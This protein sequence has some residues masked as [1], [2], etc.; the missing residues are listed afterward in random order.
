MPDESPIQRHP[1]ELLA[2]AGDRDC[3]HAAIE[4]GADAVYFGLQHGFN[5]RARAA[6]HGVG[7][8]PELMRLLHRRGLRGY[9]TLNT[10][11][12]TDELP[13]IEEAVVAIS[14][15]GVDAVLVQDLGLAR[16][17]RD[18]SPGLAVHASTQMTLT[19]AETVR[20][21]ERLGV[22]RVVV[23][24]ELSLKEIRQ[25]SEGT[26]VEVEAF[27][28][29]ALCVAYSGQ[30]LTSESLGGRSANR[31]QC[32]QACRLPYE[33]IVDGED[34]DL[35]DVKYLLSPQD[36]AAYHLVPELIDA[37]VAC[38]KIEGRLKTP[39][40][41]ANITRQ[42][43]RAIDAA[44][45]GR[46]IDF[47]RQDIAEM[48][49]SFSRGFSPGWMQGCDHK[50]L[51]PGKSSAKRG[52]R[53]GEVTAVHRQSVE[54]RLTGSL[55]LGDGVVFQGDRLEDAEQGGRV[56]TLR[57]SD[58]QSVQEVERGN[59]EIEFGRDAIDFTELYPGQTL[60]KTDDPK[61]NARLR[62]TFTGDDP[63][64][65]QPIDIQVEATAGE[66]LK[67][68]VGGVSDA[69]H[70]T[71][72]ESD[73]DNKIGVGDASYIQPLRIDSEEPLAVARKHPLTE[74]TLRE[75][76]GR[77]GGSAYELRELTATIT[78]E[79]MAP[80]SLLNKLRRAMVARLDQAAEAIPPRPLDRDA[81]H[82]LLPSRSESHEQAPAS[83]RILC[84][85][86][87][88][89]SELLELG[90]SRLMA[91]FE[92]IRQYKE[93]TQRA[94]DANA[95]LYLATPRIQKPGEAGIF[96]AMAKH[97]PSG[98]LVRNLAGIDFCNEH[99]VPFVADFSLNASNPITVAYLKELGA[100][101]VTASYDLNR[102]QL[103]DLVAQ[104]PPTWLEVVVHQHMPMF[105]ME[106]CVFCSL[107]SPGTNKTNC[108]RPCD[109][110]E[111][112]LRDRTG[113]EHRLTADVG[114]RNT[115]FN[116]SPQSAAEAIPNLLNEG[117]RHLRIELLEE[118]SQADGGGKQLRQTIALYRDLLAGRVT[119]Q[120]VWRK[121]KATNRLGVTRGT[122][123]ER[124]NPLAI[125]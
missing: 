121:L 11:I 54:V 80:L 21:A 8:L 63:Q 19:S 5:A 27:V 69:D 59:A 89:L 115:L 66:P 112:K 58:R 7:D 116:A 42:Y 52:V 87:D 120:E 2:P 13:A 86:L 47:S 48:E 104:S 68:S 67:L 53:L 3:V 28:H 39:E 36:L 44:V 117:V 73:P 83:L 16:L 106:H 123:E 107:L 101:R 95:K 102:E 62:K 71:P 9:V 4:N 103:F 70:G 75:Q 82:R 1:P 41:V 98:F 20:A 94:R 64:R 32:A 15:A 37:G 77:L 31:G 99:N 22:E 55:K 81:I 49:L 50:M 45:A 26:H 65:R 43:R 40:Y 51:V 111:V 110:H 30:C 29:G 61:L 38:L 105:H 118:R 113:A 12:F 100:E 10:L 92:D 109:R 76:L 72:A 97:E 85:T 119:G 93:A 60:W 88:Q 84:R 46:P 35:D 125:L 90:E 14:E 114:C 33:M 17:I 78:G 18:L 57:T 96:R 25:V 74:A 122:L 56:Y 108:G 6:N 79:P 91:D 124:R 34:R 23:G 24:R